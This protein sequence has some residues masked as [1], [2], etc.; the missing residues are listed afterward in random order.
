MTGQPKVART[1][2]ATYVTLKALAIEAGVPLIDTAA[3]VDYAYRY[4]DDL[5]SAQSQDVATATLRKKISRAR[6]MRRAEP[7]AR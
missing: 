4:I 3:L 1:S 6:I 5:G 7:V 2:L